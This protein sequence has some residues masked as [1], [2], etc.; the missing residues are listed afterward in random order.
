[1]KRTN[2]MDLITKLFPAHFRFPYI[3]D[4][5]LNLSLSLTLSNA[6][7][8]MFKPW[9]NSSSVSTTKSRKQLPIIF[10]LPEID[11]DQEFGGFVK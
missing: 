3:E 4:L 5:D 6:Y 7:V 10:F 8:Q 1:M 9:P 2:V 11:D